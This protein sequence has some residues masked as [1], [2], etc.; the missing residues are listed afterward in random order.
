MLGGPAVFRT[1]EHHVLEEMCVPVLAFVLI[2]RAYVVGHRRRNDG[3]GVVFNRDYTQAILER[4]FLVVN[5][6]VARLRRH[7]LRQCQANHK[8]QRKLEG[9]SHRVTP[10]YLQKLEGADFIWSIRSLSSRPF[11]VY[12]CPVGTFLP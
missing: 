6:Y 10:F 12:R 2:T 3:R 5:S 1:L 8:H 9:V 11:S 4:R 7:L